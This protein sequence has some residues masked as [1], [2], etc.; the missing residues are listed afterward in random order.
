MIQIF[1]ELFLSFCFVF[2]FVWTCLAVWREPHI[3]IIILSYR[4]PSPFI[5]V[6]PGKHE[7][8]QDTCPIRKLIRNERVIILEVKYFKTFWVLAQISLIWLGGFEAELTHF[9]L[10]SIDVWDLRS[11]HVDAPEVEVRVVLKRFASRLKSKHTWK[12]PWLP[13]RKLGQVVLWV[14]ELNFSTLLHKIVTY[15][16]CFY[17]IYYK[18][19]K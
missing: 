10:N 4:D 11:G 2:V 9:L 16:F 19:H 3:Y 13:I 7:L 15:T 17:H 6:L 1:N 5:L 8:F 14:F 12:L 18:V